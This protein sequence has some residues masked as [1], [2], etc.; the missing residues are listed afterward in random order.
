VS[1]SALKQSEKQFQGAVVEYAELNGWK[2]YHTF[3]S[4]RSDP[5]FPDLVLSR[6]DRLVFLELKSETGRA[7]TA[8][9]DWLDAL[10]RAPGITVGVMR[11][12]DWATLEEML[13][14]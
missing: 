13:S 9:R 5:G 6:D 7:S 2:T 3:D 11:P 4:R 14:R 8:Q 1:S 10:Q 12:R